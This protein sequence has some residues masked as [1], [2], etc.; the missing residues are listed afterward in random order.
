[1]LWSSNNIHCQYIR[2]RNIWL[3][4]NFPNLTFN[5][6]PCKYIYFIGKVL[7]PVAL[8]KQWLTR[9]FI[10]SK[11]VSTEGNKIFWRSVCMD[12]HSLTIR[13]WF[14]RVSC[15]LPQLN[16]GVLCKSISCLTFFHWWPNSD[17]V[18][19]KRLWMLTWS[20]PFLVNHLLFQFCFLWWC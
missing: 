12:M 2:C 3:G 4:H 13:L 14:W 8:L 18:P 6:F 19:S 17:L 20:I 15:I 11:N 10:D 9:S 1:M 16:K 5:W 7:F